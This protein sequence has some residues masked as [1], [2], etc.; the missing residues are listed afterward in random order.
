MEIANSPLPGQEVAT[1][2]LPLYG[3]IS[4]TSSRNLNPQKSSF[5]SP[6]SFQNM[7]TPNH[8]LFKSK[9]KNELVESRKEEKS[10]SLPIKE[11][12]PPPPPHKCT[13]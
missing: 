3:S 6:S 13:P 7:E 5:P 12:E 11:V 10:T 9:G 1:S 8:E 4:S 2:P